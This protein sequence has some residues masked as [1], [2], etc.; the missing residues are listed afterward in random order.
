MR[1]VLLTV[2]AGALLSGCGTASTAVVGGDPVDEPYAGPMSLPRS[3]VDRATPLQQSGA[4]GRALECDD[5]VFRGGGGDYLDGLVEV[6][7]GPEQALENWLDAEGWAMQL[8][9]TGYR[10]ERDD[11]DRV[12]LSY[13]VQGRTKIAVITADGI[14]DYQ[15][16]DWWGVESWSMCDPAELPAPVTEDLDWG[17]WADVTGDR[18]PVT[19]IVSYRGSEHCDWQDLTFLHT[20]S[21]RHGQQYVRDVHGELA[22]WLTTTYDA[23]ADLPD[24]AIDTGLRR[25]DRQLW[26]DVDPRAAYLVSIVDPADVERWPA[27]AKEPIGCA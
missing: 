13:D 17:V 1:R 11:G 6:Q 16:D 19:R 18:V 10:V 22:P 8:P 12:L 9:L 4:A 23:D 24:T 15:G 3:F 5:E 25:D 2:A 14:R 21:E 20:G 7:P 26:I 27:A